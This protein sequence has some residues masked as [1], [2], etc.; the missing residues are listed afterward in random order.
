MF[1][2]LSQV[3]HSLTD[4]IL[5]YIIPRRHN[6]FKKNVELVF[7]SGFGKKEKQLEY[8]YLKH[9]VLFLK[10]LIFFKKYIRKTKVE[11]YGEKYIKSALRKEKGV[12]ILS[13]HL[14]NWELILPLWAKSF[15]H[16]HPA[17]FCIR[18]KLKPDWFNRMILKR[19]E[20]KGIT[21]IRSQGGLGKVIKALKHNG[22]V[23]FALDQRT[24]SREGLKVPFFGQSCH[25][26]S[27]LAKLSN[28]Y[29][30]PVIP[31]YTYREN[32]HAHKLIFQPEINHDVDDSIE[33]KTTRYNKIIEQFILKHPEQWYCWVHDRW[34][35]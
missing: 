21:I 11:V 3:I 12:I 6:I 29:G 27:S 14:G 31:M 20:F 7:K 33:Q 25:T 2:H 32:N 30:V 1:L 17:I 13:S 16:I 10:E 4:R 34:R 28:K 15:S 9:L 26:H 8:E 23:F 22:I 5:H 19:F 18:R 24:N 35:L